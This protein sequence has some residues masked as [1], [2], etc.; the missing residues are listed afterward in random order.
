MTVND[1]DENSSECWNEILLRLRRHQWNI[2]FWKNGKMKLHT[3]FFKLQTFSKPQQRQSMPLNRL[4][5]QRCWYCAIIW[6]F[7]TSLTRLPASSLKQHYRPRRL[8]KWNVPT[9]NQSINHFICPTWHL[10]YRCNK[11]SSEQDKQ[12]MKCTYSRVDNWL[13]C[14]SHCNC[15]VA[16]SYE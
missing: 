5:Y 8:P 12:G 6:R 2:T 16:T 14:C 4:L 1:Y 15:C 10:R 9:L 3:E 7:Y 13:Q 11:Q